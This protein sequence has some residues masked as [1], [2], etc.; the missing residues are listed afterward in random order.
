MEQAFTGESVHKM[1]KKGRASVPAAYRRVLAEGDPDYVPG[2]NFHVVIVYS[3]C[4]D[5]CLVGYTKKAKAELNR[6]IKKLPS[7]SRQRKFLDRWLNA[8]SAEL[9]IDPD[10]RFVLPDLVRKTV[11]LEAGEIVF[12]G[13]G[14]TFQIWDPKLYAQDDA[15]LEEEFGDYNSPDN[16]FAM[17]DAVS[18]D[19]PEDDA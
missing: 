15:G 7:F 8:K 3:N 2:G 16:P 17:L 6:K 4:G 1:D 18:L 12:A 19:E 13:M 14:E 5:Q 10:G 11:E 9:A